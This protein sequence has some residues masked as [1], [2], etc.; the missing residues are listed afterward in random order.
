VTVVSIP[1]DTI[2]FVELVSSALPV[3]CQLLHS[4][5]VTDII[6]AIEFFTSAY[7]F[8]M[9]GAIVGVQQ[10]LVLMWSRDQAVRDAVA[11]SYKKLYLSTE[12]TTPRYVYNLN[13]CTDRFVSVMLT[14]SE[15]N[16]LC[17]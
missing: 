5:Q 7:Q 13:L 10:M 14:P 17:S 12:S 3:I 11:L 15:L 4:R 16:E 6:E 2:I 1:Q 9:A 8:G